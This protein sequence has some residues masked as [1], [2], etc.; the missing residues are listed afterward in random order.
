ME[1]KQEIWLVVTKYEIWHNY[2]QQYKVVFKYKKITY[3]K[4]T[5]PSMSI[6]MTLIDTNC[7]CITHHSIE[8]L[9]LE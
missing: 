8:L 1:Q 2:L 9:T 3:K 5:C 6:V 7:D 4:L